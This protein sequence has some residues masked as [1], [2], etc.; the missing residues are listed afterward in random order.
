M[1][2]DAARQ[3]TTGIPETVRGAIATAPSADP[4]FFIRR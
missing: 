1:D 2:I 3:T 4:I